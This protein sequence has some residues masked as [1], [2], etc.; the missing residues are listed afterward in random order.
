MMSR[1]LILDIYEAF[2]DQFTI[3]YKKPIDEENLQILIKSLNTI[4]PLIEELISEYEIDIQS[5]SYMEK[6]M[7]MRI[8]FPEIWK[9]Q[10]QEAK[11]SLASTKSQLIELGRKHKLDI[12]QIFK[13]HEDKKLSLDDFST[14]I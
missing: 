2:A 12:A 10:I 9:I 13:I 4:D 5:L 8:K 3:G 7:E 14:I 1:K 11:N 6:E